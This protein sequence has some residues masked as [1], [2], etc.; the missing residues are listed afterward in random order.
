MKKNILNLISGF[1]LILSA[2]VHAQQPASA[3]ISGIAG[4]NNNWIFYQNAYGN[5]ELEYSVATINY[6]AGIGINY[7]TNK[8]GVDVSVLRNRMGQSYGGMQAKGD[9]KRKIRLTYIEVPLMVWRNI[10]FK[11][12]PTWISFGPDVLILLKASQ[13]YMREG[14][15]ELQFP[16]RMNTGEITSRFNKIDVALRFSY[17]KI[18][19]IPNIEKAKL[20]LSANAA[21]GMSDINSSEWRIKEPAG[22]YSASHNF[23]MGIKAAI[24]FR[25]WRKYNPW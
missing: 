2:P 13:E 15:M 8:W 14:G 5:P 7:L 12:N 4:F 19:D 9:T 17:S 18:F 11:K 1:L 24:M 25:V 21:I 3:W 10:P 20:V 6:T 16:D 22:N 23:Y